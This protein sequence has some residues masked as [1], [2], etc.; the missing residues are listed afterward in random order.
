MIAC[1]KCGCV[2]LSENKFDN[3]PFSRVAGDALVSTRGGRTADAISNLIAWVG[4]QAAN[5]VRKPH[6]CDHCEHTVD[7]D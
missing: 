3:V 5:A 6:K 1:P 7:F 2:T 4:L